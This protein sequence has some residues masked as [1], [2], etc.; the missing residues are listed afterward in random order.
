MIEGLG[1]IGGDRVVARIRRER[2]PF[3]ERIVAGWPQ[4][5][6]A[7]RALSLGFVPDRSF[8]DILKAHIE[9]E[10]GGAIAA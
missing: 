6:D 5:F 1:R 10:L 2:D 9:E 7:K 3:I 4:R 8:E